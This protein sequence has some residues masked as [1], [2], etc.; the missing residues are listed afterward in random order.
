MKRTRRSQES[1]GYVV[2]LNTEEASRKVRY[3]NDRIVVKA[4]TKD[5]APP[6]MFPR[7]TQTRDSSRAF[8]D[9]DD[10]SIFGYLSSYQK[11]H[12]HLKGTQRQSN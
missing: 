12:R 1:G 5:R 11:H 2:V 7:L 3:M 8:A 6:M 10:L 9:L 4:A